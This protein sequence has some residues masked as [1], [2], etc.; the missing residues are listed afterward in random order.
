MTSRVCVLGALT[1][2]LSTPGPVAAQTPARDAGAMRPPVG[3][4]SVSGTLVTDDATSR[5]IRRA[6]VTLT[7]P[8]QRASHLTMTDDAGA[9]VFR[10]LAAGRYTITA[11]RAGF[12]DATYGAK[13]PRGLGS[14][15]S[16]AEGEHRQGLTLKMLRGAVISGT[17][18]DAQGE[19]LP[20][21]TV[22]VMGYAYAYT[23]ERILG[24]S[25]RALG[26][27]TQTTDDRGMYRM[28]G[29]PPGE[30]LVLVTQGIVSRL[31]D[32]HQTTAE[33]V[34]WATRA[35]QQGNQPGARASP[36][37]A[38]AP[39]VAY[40]P[41]FHPGTTSPRN[42]ATVTVAA[43]E[44]RSNVDVDVLPIP[45]A[46]LEGTIV[47]ARRERAGDDAGRPRRAG[48]HRRSAAQRLL[49]HDGHEREIHLL[50]SRAGPL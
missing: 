29:L 1:A 43:G 13:R 4:A 19:P 22:S 33:D 28:Y 36:A 48:S 27:A 34:Q 12:I 25:S 3:T 31:V 23:G 8:D 5:P 11:K 10:D 40:A 21:Q 41:V 39:A 44:E 18:R 24:L 45:T 49:E 2:L 30:Y 14:A 20:G 6:T 26:L 17:V 42:A 7:P 37:P 32:A 15:V 46:T 38:P 47:G 50:G 9:F 35:V 16:V